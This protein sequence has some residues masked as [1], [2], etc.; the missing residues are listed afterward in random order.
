VRV[1]R[2]TLNARGRAH[3]ETLVRELVERFRDAVRDA[4]TSGHRQLAQIAAGA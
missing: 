2:L 1:P 4:Y 3:D